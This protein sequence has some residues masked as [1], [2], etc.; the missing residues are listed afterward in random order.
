[1]YTMKKSGD[2][3]CII[4]EN[5]NLIIKKLKNKIKAQYYY[6]HFKK[7]GGYNGFTPNFILKK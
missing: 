3:Y 2:F 4:E 1:M 6:S 7:G 5:T